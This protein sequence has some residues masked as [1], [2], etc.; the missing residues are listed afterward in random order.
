MWDHTADGQWPGHLVV[1]AQQDHSYDPCG[2][3]I[4]W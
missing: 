3:E 1:L 4:L 2:E